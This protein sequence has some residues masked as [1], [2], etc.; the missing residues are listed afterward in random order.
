MSRLRVFDKTASTNNDIKQ[1][2][3]AGEPEGL[4]ISSLVQTAGYGRLGRTWESPK[5]GM[6]VSCLLRPH[7][8]TCELPSLSLVTALAVRRALENFLSTE[9][10][11]DIKIKWPND[12]VV[13]SNLLTQ[14]RN[15]STLRSADALHLAPC[16][17]HG[18]QR[19]ALGSAAEQYEAPQR[20]SLTLPNPGD[21]T[22]PDSYSKLCGISLEVHNEAV[23]IGIGVNVFPP[24][25][26]QTQFPDTKNS[27]AYL[28]DLTQE[29][30]PV[31][32]HETPN[33]ISVE[34]VRTAVLASLSHAYE[35]WQTSGFAVFLPEYEACSYLTG[36]YV[37][38]E[39]IDG[40]PL[41][42]GLVQGI[43]DQGALILLPGKG[44][45]P[46]AASSGEAHIGRISCSQ[47]A[48]DQT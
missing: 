26:T 11:Q 2:I 29:N 1:A 42:T 9:I 6:Y 5:G 19:S 44:Q 30:A 3:D 45:K 33:T 28:S 14:I 12:I 17:E 31:D 4:A 36:L 15:L 21:L 47:K 23:C 7:V 40:S 39:N 16:A 18:A 13:V 20:S 24:Q 37:S 10:L 32:S 43:N 46:F 22:D 25:E 35:Q 38:L 41:A 34:R 27:P 8:L 48:T